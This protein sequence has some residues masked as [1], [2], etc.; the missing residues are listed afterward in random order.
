MQ[1]PR[2]MTSSPQAHAS[3][4]GPLHIHRETEQH[5]EL[6]PDIRRWAGPLVLGHMRACP[7]VTRH[8]PEVRSIYRTGVSPLARDGG[9]PGLTKT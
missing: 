2:G 4:R 8:A 7:K 9:V 3:N 5:A 1:S 6:R